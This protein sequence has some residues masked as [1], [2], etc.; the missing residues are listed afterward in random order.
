VH[1][2]AVLPLIPPPI[3][4]SDDARMWQNLL[5]PAFSSPLE[6][7]HQLLPVC[8]FPLSARR[9]CHAFSRPGLATLTKLTP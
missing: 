2:P 5:A 1:T 7:E 8:S 4:S 3:W 6:H 9:L